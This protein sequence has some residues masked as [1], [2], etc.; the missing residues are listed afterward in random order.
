MVEVKAPGANR[1]QRRCGFPTLQAGR[2]ALLG[3]H[4]PLLVIPASLYGHLVYLLIVFRPPR[5]ALV[6]VPRVPSINHCM[7]TTPET[8]TLALV[9]LSFLF[10]PS[11]S[12]VLSRTPPSS[13]C[14][15]DVCFA[16]AEALLPSY[17]PSQRP[18]RTRD[19]P[20]WQM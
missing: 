12:L 10:L 14:S 18:T 13:P 4:C 5:F 20:L 17:A 16:M 2:T 15:L 11:S 7:K 8:I 6:S 3:I 1:F 19:L 9:E